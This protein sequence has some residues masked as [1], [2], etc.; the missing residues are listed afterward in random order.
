[1]NK[2]GRILISRIKSD[3]KWNKEANDDKEDMIK[4]DKKVTLFGRKRNKNNDCKERF[5]DDIEVVNTG[6]QR[7]R[8][9]K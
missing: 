9:N 5:T 1:M 8:I 7:A 2:G 4:N 6:K 3:D